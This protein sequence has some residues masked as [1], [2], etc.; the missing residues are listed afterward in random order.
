MVLTADVKQLKG[1]EMGL[2]TSSCAS[3]EL[4]RQAAWASLGPE[5]MISGG[6][7]ELLQ[8]SPLTAVRHQGRTV[9]LC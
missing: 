7:Q 2:L 1:V 6:R 9:C 4:G 8:S 3:Q 5:A